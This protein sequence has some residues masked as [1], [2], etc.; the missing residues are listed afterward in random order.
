MVERL[1]GNRP[2]G[3]VSNGSV[4]DKI[5]A[6]LGELRQAIG[7]AVQRRSTAYGYERS[8]ERQEMQ[9]PALPL[10]T[11]EVAGNVARAQR[12]ATGVR[13]TA[14]AWLRTFAGRVLR[15]AQPWRSEGGLGAWERVL[16]LLRR[17]R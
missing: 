13:R 4:I 5:R 2:L 12:L 11:P 8:P 15:S 17:R 10:A 6:V 3:V 9:R 7:D 16:R 14:L 1:K